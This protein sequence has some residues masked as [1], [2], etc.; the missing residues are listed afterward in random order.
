MKFITNDNISI[1]YTI[2]GSGNTLIFLAGYS[3]IKEE[4]IKQVEFFVKKGYQV[5]TFDARNHGHSTHKLLNLKIARLGQ[6]LAQLIDYLNLKNVTLIGHS[7]GGAT[8]WAYCMLYG[9]QNLKKIVT[10]DESPYAINYKEWQYGINNLTWDNLGVN[11]Q[12]VM[13]VKMNSLPIDENLKQI[14]KAEHKKYPFDFDKNIILLKNHLTQDWRDLIAKID[15]EQLY[16]A[17]EKSPLWSANHAKKCVDINE[18]RMAKSYV[19]KGAGH[20]PHLEC[21]DEFNNVVYEFLK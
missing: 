1:E 3:G 16:L 8:I 11:V 6:D 20:L 13:D 2:Q 7:M 18:K 12:Y 21:T 9:T 19:F 17:G 5:V 14:L 4:W 10:V 15:V